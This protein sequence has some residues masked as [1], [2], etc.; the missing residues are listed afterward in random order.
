MRTTHGAWFLSYGLWTKPD[1]SRYTHPA[2]RIPT[3]L[4]PAMAK[5]T[6]GQTMLVLHSGATRARAPFRLWRSK[7]KVS[8]Y[9]ITVQWSWNFRGGKKHEAHKIRK[10]SLERESYGKLGNNLHNGKK[11]LDLRYLNFRVKCKISVQLD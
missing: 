4:L 3:F 8:Y 11:S 10:F 6:C 5:H 1:N 9:W 2:L 7:R